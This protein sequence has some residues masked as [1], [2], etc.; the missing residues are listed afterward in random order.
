[1][2]L[3]L[4]SFMLQAIARLGGHIMEQECYQL[5]T[6]C[7]D[8]C[9]QEI[10][11][12]IKH[13]EDEI[14][15]IKESLEEF[16]SSHLK[17]QKSHDL[18]QENY[19][20][21]TKRFSLLQEYHEEIKNSYASLQQKLAKSQQDTVP[22]N[23]RDKHLKRKSLNIKKKKINYGRSYVTFF[24]YIIKDKFEKGD[25]HKSSQY[26]RIT[27]YSNGTTETQRSY[28]R[29]GIGNSKMVG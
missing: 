7:L 20:E 12:N 18:L 5:K 26:K 3:R 11:M 9:N 29:L 23:V 21:G 17:L 27:L 19:K 24:I 15:E 4:L 25:I 10:V 13:S 6:K 28:S 2:H 14:K 1:M 8:Y 16:K 22:W